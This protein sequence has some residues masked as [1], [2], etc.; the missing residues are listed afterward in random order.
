MADAA[1]EA[2]LERQAEEDQ[3][4]GTPTIESLQSQMLAMERRH[5]EEVAN[6]RR[7][8]PPPRA[9]EPPAPDPEPIE[10]LLFTEPKRAVEKLRQQVRAEIEASLTQKYNQDQNTQKFWT[11]FEQKHPDLSPVRSVVEGI[12]NQNLDQ[13]ANVPI[14]DAMDKLA[15]L[16][17]DTLSKYN[18]PRPRG[19]RP[20]AEGASSPTPPR[21]AAEDENPPS[22][23]DI[24]RRRRAARMNRATVA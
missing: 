19:R 16:T 13:L 18:Q 3:R 5:A 24:V 8:M 22:L 9:V 2:E 14:E 6:L 23:S 10:Q 12:L 20:F 7:T 15:E 17:R 21:Q 1:E 11:Q 4:N